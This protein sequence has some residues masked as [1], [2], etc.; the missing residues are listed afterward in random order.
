MSRFV[1][2]ST[3]EDF[4]IVD[5]LAR[6][7]HHPIKKTGKEHFYHSM[8][9][10]TK[11]D[12]PSFTVWDAGHCW[13][14]WGGANATG[15]FKGGIVQ[16][17][18]AYWPNLSFV[19]VL[20][21]IQEVCNMDTAL[22][23]EYVP[24]QTYHP[25]P[26]KGE[27]EWSLVNLRDLGGNFILTKYMEGRGLL[28]VAKDHQVQ[29]VYYKRKN[30]PENS[31]IYY[32]VGWQNEHGGWEFSNAKG[33]K[34]TIGQ[35]GIS[36]ILGNTD[37]VVAFEGYMDFLSWKRLHPDQRP[38][39]IVLNAIT[40]LGYAI[41]RLKTFQKIDVFFDNDDPGR[42]CTKELSDQIP[43]AVDCSYEYEGLK[44]Y[45]EKLKDMITSQKTY[46]R[47]AAIENPFSGNGR[48]R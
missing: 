5:F 48:K 12:T 24:P 29:E 31:S 40:M 21:K 17:G 8:L 47:D 2:I 25:D 34:S 20:N 30:S 16:L 33:F 46:D 6:L 37:H 41:E 19:E 26:K 42:R 43:W 1:D 35:K 11:K 27:Y 44:D 14:D 39:V 45:N 3:L 38:S 7:G 4:S 22:I 10:E 18:I 32:A 15:V 36:I 28:D 13:K 9:R 23:P